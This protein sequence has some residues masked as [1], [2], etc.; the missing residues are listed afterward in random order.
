MMRS[1]AYMGSLTLNQDPGFSPCCHGKAMERE[2]TAEGQDSL[3][4]PFKELA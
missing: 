1:E 2:L 4:F 3:I